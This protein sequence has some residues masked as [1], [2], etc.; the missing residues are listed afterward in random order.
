MPNLLFL[1][2]FNSSP[3]SAKAEQLRSYLQQHR[4]DWQLIA[5][6]LASTPM[7]CWQQ[8]QQLL[9]EQPIDAV[10]GSSLGG[11]FATLIAEGACIPAALVNPAVAPA[12]LLLDALG[13]HTNPYTGE[14]YRLEHSHIEE[15]I[16]L[17]PAAISPSRY[18]VLVTT[19]DEVLDYRQAVQFYRG[20]RIDVIS[21]GDH[22]F[23]MFGQ[24]IAEIFRFYDSSISDW[25][26]DTG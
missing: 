5:P 18:M 2:G 26:H 14:Q 6:Q 24:H 11:F 1:H 9:S 7:A 23:T 3:E 19:G 4:P 21:G 13:E 10:V 25:R 8:L 20:A 22:L 17:Q 12:K 15:L 16:Q